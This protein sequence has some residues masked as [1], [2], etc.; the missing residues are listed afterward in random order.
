MKRDAFINALLWGSGSLVTGLLLVIIGFTV[1]ESSPFLFNNISSGAWQFDRWAPSEQ[2]WN[3]WPMLLG[4]IVVGMGAILLATPLALFSVV[5]LRY[6]MPSLIGRIGRRMIELA[7]GIPTVVFG[8]WG[9]VTL[10]PLIAQI[11]QPGASLL[12][13]IVILALMIL[14]TTALL[15]DQALAALPDQYQRSAQALGIH[16]ITAAWRI[17]VPAAKRGIGIGTALGLARALGETM[18]VMM[19]CGNIVQVPDS[20]FAPIRTLTANIALEMAYAMDTHR[21][22]L[23]VSGVLLTLLTGV[24]ALCAGAMERHAMAQPAN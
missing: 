12:A 2:Q 15:M 7:A 22:A 1:S 3:L 13:G 4:S 18:A 16:P 21:A 23:F 8:F 6:Q 17:L 5:A 10:V 24:L 9:L 19:V 11:Q 14:P 20:L